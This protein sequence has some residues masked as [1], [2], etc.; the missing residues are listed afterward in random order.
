MTTDTIGVHMRRV[1]MTLTTEHTRTHIRTL[2]AMLLMMKTTTRVTP[3][4]WCKTIASA[5]LVRA[6]T[7]ITYGC[8]IS[9]LSG[10]QDIT[11]NDATDVITVSVLPFVVTITIA[12]QGNTSNALSRHRQR[13]YHHE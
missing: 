12:V 4:E 13:Q 6:C 7:H 9:S 8:C 10:Y 5:D 2:Q 11:M 1:A 3:C